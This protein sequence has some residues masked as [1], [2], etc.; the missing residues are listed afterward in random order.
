MIQY[1]YIYKYYIIFRQHQKGNLTSTNPIASIYAWT[2]GL[3]HRAML[4]NTPELTK[5]IS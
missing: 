3:K 2:R 5:Y 4:D 1:M